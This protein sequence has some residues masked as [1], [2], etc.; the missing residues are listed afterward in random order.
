MDTHD[1]KTDA[2]AVSI[3]ASVHSFLTDLRAVLHCLGHW[4]G[5]SGEQAGQGGIKAEHRMLGYEP[6]WWHPALSAYSK[7]QLLR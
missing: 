3:L 2:T 5:S 7:R 6:V 4:G 1:L